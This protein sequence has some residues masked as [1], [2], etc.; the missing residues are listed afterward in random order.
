[1]YSI[2]SHD[3]HNEKSDEPLSVCVGDEIDGMQFRFSADENGKITSLNHDKNDYG[4]HGACQMEETN[5]LLEEFGAKELKED[6]PAVQT[7]LQPVNLPLIF[8]KYFTILRPEWSE[9]QKQLSD[10]K[11]ASVVAI[12]NACGQS[13]SKSKAKAEKKGF[14]KTVS[15]FVKHLLV[16]YFVVIKSLFNDW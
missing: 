3:A 10:G 1:M 5:A 9:I 2:A 7:Q 15:N 8:S 16:R 4:I 11:D 13:E 6:T 12:C 14:Y